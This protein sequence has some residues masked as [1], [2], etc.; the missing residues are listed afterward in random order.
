MCP[1]TFV[2]FNPYDHVGHNNKPSDTMIKPP[3]NQYEPY[4]DIL[5]RLTGYA[6][7]NT[8]DKTYPRFNIYLTEESIHG[9]YDEAV[10][11]MHDV[12]EN[13][14]RYLRKWYCFYISEVPFGVT[15]TTGTDGQKIWS[16]NGKGELNAYRGVSSLPDKNGNEEIFWGREDE[17]CRFKVGDIVEIPAH[18]NE[19][20][21]GIICKMPENFEMVRRTLPE[22]KPENPLR[23]HRDSSDDMYKVICIDDELAD[24]YDVIRCFPAETFTLDE[25]YVR[26]LQECLDAYI[27]LAR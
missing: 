2:H 16:F 12:I 13:D 26:K 8:A 1:V 6:V 14:E 15:C 5:Y 10:A 25:S 7:T 9:T 17:D 27:E 3:Y 20:S 11:K 19:V 22:E 4:T 21:I 23:F 24:Y 18:Y